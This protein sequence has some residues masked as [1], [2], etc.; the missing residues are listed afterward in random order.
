MD[1][2]VQYTTVKPIYKLNT[3]CTVKPIYKL[4]TTCTVKPIYKLNTTCTVKPIYK[5][6]T[7]CTVKPIYK[8][9]TMG[10]RQNVQSK[11]PVHT[12]YK[13]TVSSLDTKYHFNT[14]KQVHVLNKPFLACNIH[15]CFMNQSQK[16]IHNL[17]T[18]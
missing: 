2:Y 7:T 16:A 11:M 5:L 4:N 6:N 17:R 13:M 3:T 9:N 1:I 8:L 10:I 18:V 12:V 15:Y 14:T